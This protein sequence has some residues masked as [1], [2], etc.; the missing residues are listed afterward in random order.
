MKYN[1][2]P[3][4]INLIPIFLTYRCYQKTFLKL[5]YWK[6]VRRRLLPP[7]T[8]YCYIYLLSTYFTAKSYSSSTIQV[9]DSLKTIPMIGFNLIFEAGTQNLSTFSVKFQNCPKFMGF[10]WLGYFPSL[11][12]RSALLTPA[13]WTKIWTWPFSGSEI[14]LLPTFKTSGPPNVW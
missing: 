14:S 8:Q 4:I 5:S 12:M 13:Q 9:I 7:K 2:I 1:L 6:S 3:S 11:C 10:F